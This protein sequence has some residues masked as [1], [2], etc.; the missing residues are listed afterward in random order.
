ARVTR[1]GQRASRTHVL[2]LSRSGA[3]LQAAAPRRPAVRARAGVP[4]GPGGRCAADG[5]FDTRHGVIAS[6]LA[7]GAGGARVCQAWPG[8]GMSTVS[9]VGLMPLMDTNAHTPADRDQKSSHGSRR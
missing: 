1:R 6:V 3:C 7:G 5:G 9:A 2:I 8:T 4:I